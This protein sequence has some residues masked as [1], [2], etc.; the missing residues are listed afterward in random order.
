MK[1]RFTVLLGSVAFIWMPS[2][3]ADDLV[4][5]QN[6]PLEKVEFYHSRPRL[7]IEDNSPIVTDWRK[8]QQQT[9]YKI[10]IP[11]APKSMNQ[12]VI[13]SA[14]PSSDPAPNLVSGRPLAPAGFNS[15]INANRAKAKSLPQGNSIGQHAIG[16]LLKASKPSQALPVRHAQ[17]APPDNTP[18]QALTYGIT[19]TP[20]STSQQFSSKSQVIGTLLKK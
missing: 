18:K 20:A 14:P 5:L 7:G 8:R 16:N 17:N 13:L 11:P 2:A 10:V 4:N 3:F 12:E 15:N 19:H 9:T 6:R 1:N